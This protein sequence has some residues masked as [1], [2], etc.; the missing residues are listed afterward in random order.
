MNY[1]TPRQIEKKGVMKYVKKNYEG[2]HLFMFN[3]H[4][5]VFYYSRVRKCFVSFKFGSSATLEQYLKNEL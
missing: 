5:H 3:I 1:E 2:K 4:D